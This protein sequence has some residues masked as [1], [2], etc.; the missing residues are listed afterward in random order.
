[1]C[2]CVLVMSMWCSAYNFVRVCVCV[3]VYDPSVWVYCVYGIQYCVWA[4][5]FVPQ[6]QSSRLCVHILL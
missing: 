4:V 2:M 3:C 1:M 5:E 6:W